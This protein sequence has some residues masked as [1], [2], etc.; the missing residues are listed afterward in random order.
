V[1]RSGLDL[2]VST[3]KQKLPSTDQKKGG[4]NRQKGQTALGG[5]ELDGP[6][7][8][9]IF[10]RTL[11]GNTICMQ[12]RTGM[13]IKNFRDDIQELL[14]IPASLLNLVYAGHIL[15]E[16]FTV[17]HYGIVKDST[18]FLSTRLRGGSFGSSSKG[19]GSFKDA[20]KG[21]GEA[22][23]KFTAANN[24]PGQY[25]VDQM[26][27]NP[28]VSLDIPEVKCL[29]TDLQ[30]NAVICRFNGFWPKTDALYQWVHTVWAKNCRIHLCSKGFFIVIFQEGG[31]REKILN[32]GPW[33][34]GNTGLFVTPWF[35]EFDANSMVVTRMPVWV[36]LHNLPIHFWHYKTLT[37]IGNTLGRMLK[38]DAERHIKGIFTF[39]RICVEVDLSKGLPES[40]ILNFNNSQ[41]KQTLDYENTAFSC[42]G[43][44]QTG[45][46]YNTCKSIN[47]NKPQQK[48]AKGWQHVDK[49][50]KKSTV[51]KAAA[52]VTE[53]ESTEVEED[54][55][56]TAEADTENQ[57]ENM[58]ESS[59]AQIHPNEAEAQENQA[60][61]TI[62][63]QSMGG[64]KRQH[65][66]DTSDSDK[67]TGSLNAKT[68]L[69][70]VSTEPTQGEWR[71]V[72]KKKG[73]KT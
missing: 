58:A 20:V 5:T 49:I 52:S 1:N 61:M 50:F 32:E 8:I 53:D 47:K 14:G 30:N 59:D 37:A 21:K 38:I 46:L 31:G 35:P 16:E 10:I 51:E 2:T 40:I 48:K 63:E 43:C 69:A 73:R 24:P 44:Q 56:T 7:A 17:K 3:N 29:F 18:I 65:H 13:L 60:E 68:Q 6:E 42:R 54:D 4:I 9:Q 71:K 62:G 28:S 23:N 34:W 36:W 25:I 66:P 70:I 33:F 15:L 57:E 12:A 22:T 26:P 41:W 45:H 67:D 64:I 39:A 11:T 72:E 55:T 27:E 19:T